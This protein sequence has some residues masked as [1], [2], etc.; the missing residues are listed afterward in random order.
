MKKSGQLVFPLREKFVAMV[1]P[2]FVVDFPYPGIIHGL[3]K[4][5]FDK[6]VELTFGAKL[7]NQEYHKELKKE[8]FFISSVCPGI[9]NIVLEKFPEYKDNLLKV[10]SPMVAMA[11]I[12]RKTYPSHKVVFISPCFYKKEE[13]KN[14]GQVDFVID[15]R[16]L[17]VLFDNKK[18]NLNLKKKIHFDKFYNDYTKIY[19]I[20]GGLSK[21]AHLRGVLKKGEVKVI[22]GISKVIKFLENRDKKVRFLDCNFCVGGCIGGPYINSKDSLAKRKKRVRDYLKRSL[23]EDIPEPRKGLSKRAKGINFTTNFSH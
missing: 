22:D 13:A 12:V 4:L 7:V 14:S 17:K 1:A 18:I 3:K 10:D 5:G 6:V 9:V 15:Y 19:P 21:T 2:S 11:K 20:G 23:K 16:E 8:G